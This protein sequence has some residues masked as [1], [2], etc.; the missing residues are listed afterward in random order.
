MDKDI[1]LPL[2]D[3]SLSLSL[4]SRRK[5]RNQLYGTKEVHKKMTYLQEEKLRNVTE[6]LKLIQRKKELYAQK[7]K[8]E[9]YKEIAVEDK[10]K[11]KEFAKI[12]N[13]PTIIKVIP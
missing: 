8:K 1:K 12:Q 13:N 2:I 5:R 6:Q 4:I 11:N 9:Y 10:S 7:A 3:G